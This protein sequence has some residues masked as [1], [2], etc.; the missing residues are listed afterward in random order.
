M[1]PATS[2]SSS[3]SCTD[4]TR[5]E[6]AVECGGDPMDVMVDAP[7]EASLI[8]LSISGVGASGMRR[9]F[10]PVGIFGT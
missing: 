10:P 4:A 3:A 5:L 7:S 8:F 2:S 9:L 6:G 1:S